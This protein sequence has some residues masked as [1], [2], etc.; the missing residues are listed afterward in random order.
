MEYKS[1]QRK[2]LN[3]KSTEELKNELLFMTR[4]LDDKNVSYE[5]KSEFLN[6]DIPNT[7]ENMEIIEDILSTRKSK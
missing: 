2:D 7:K 3:E 4:R 6:S 5:Q 1:M